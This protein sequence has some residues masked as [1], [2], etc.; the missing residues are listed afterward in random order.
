VARLRVVPVGFTNPEHE[1][2]RLVLLLALSHCAFLPPQCLS[3][4]FRIPLASH[5]GTW[6]GPLYTVFRYGVIILHNRLTV[7]GRSA[8]RR[9]VKKSMFTKQHQRLRELLIRERQDA[10][11]TQAELARR[12]CHHQPYVSRYEQGERRLDVIEFLDVTKAL[13]VD[14]HELLRRLESDEPLH[15]PDGQTRDTRQPPGPEQ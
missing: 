15:E 12:L 6:G 8:G 9:P 2:S 10:G 5:R 13:G 3:D 7:S 1:V 4:P 11:L 14:P